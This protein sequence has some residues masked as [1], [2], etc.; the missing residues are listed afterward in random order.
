M[1]MHQVPVK[2]KY[3]NLKSGRRHLKKSERIFGKEPSFGDGLFLIV[4]P[5]QLP[6]VK[7]NA[8]L[9]VAQNTL[10]SQ[11]DIS[12]KLVGSG[13]YTTQTKI[14]II[15]HHRQVDLKFSKKNYILHPSLGQL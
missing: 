6:R 8:C 10:T 15:K 2:A 12:A 4:D 14:M 13:S 9:L 3:Q 7:I 11:H 1:Q 5:L